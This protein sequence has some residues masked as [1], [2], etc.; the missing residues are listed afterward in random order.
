MQYGAIPTSLLE[1]VALTAGLVPIPV[2]DTM[3]GM[4]KARVVM[5]G[6]SLGIFE[7]LA[8][9]SHTTASLAAALKLDAECLEM[10]LRSLVFCRYLELD[11]ERYTLSALG[12]RSMV[13]GAP[14]DLTGFVRWN[15]TQWDFTA[16]LETLVRTGEGVDFHHTMNDPAAW[17]HYQK[18]MLETARFDAPVLAKR[19]PVRRGA[20]RL[21]DVAGS[22]GLLGAAICRRHPPMR[23]TVID[24]PAAV[25]HARALAIREGIA[26][27]VEHREGDLT[28]DDLGEGWDVVLLSNIL[29]HFR[30][31][32]IAAIL[33]R[34]QRATAGGG[35]VAI[36]E[37]E[38]P[39]RTAAPNEGDGVALFFRLTSTAGAYS[40][41]EYADWL[42][43]AG[44][45]AVTIVRPRL[46][47]GNVL[48]HARR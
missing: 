10:L 40:G 6:V 38:R 12:R 21:L 19:I 27:I 22:H 33:A 30:A 7:A 13:D 23:S 3:F 25:A 24:L 26:D 41:E 48:V 44:F 39:R 46:S 4:L 15:Y 2:L 8:L 29:H 42:R 20:A 45:G 18:A 37:L 34:V 32:Q 28:R 47:P 9:E 36:W 1:R 31:E 17:A 5:A 35:T 16:H 11:G 43:Q 14:R